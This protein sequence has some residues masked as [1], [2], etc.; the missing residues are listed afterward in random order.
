[1]TDALAWTALYGHLHPLANRSIS[2]AHKLIDSG[3]SMSLFLNAVVLA[4]LDG[5]T[6]RSRWR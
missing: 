6:R 1:M 2:R 5:P 3:I 4:K